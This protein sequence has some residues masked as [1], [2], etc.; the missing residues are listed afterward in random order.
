MNDDKKH[1]DCLAL[2]FFVRVKF[3]NLFFQITC[4]LNQSHEK[5]LEH[6]LITFLSKDPVMIQQKSNIKPFNK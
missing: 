4:E 1:N 5:L 6:N 2:K 3:L